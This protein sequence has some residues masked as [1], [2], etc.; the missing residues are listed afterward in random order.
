MPNEP[1]PIRRYL[2][3]AALAVAG[4]L[5]LLMLVPPLIS[6]FAEPPDDTSVVVATTSTAAA[7]PLLVEVALNRSHALPGEV[8]DGSHARITVVVA[9]DL[10]TGYSVVDAWSPSNEC[11]ITIGVDR[12]VDCEGATWTFAGIA[13]DPAHPNLVRFPAHDAGPS[14]IADFTRTLDLAG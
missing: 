6:S 14:V 12:L 2:V 7:G 13:I 4:V 10:A 5:V 1:P 3:S 11:A 8:A 9:P